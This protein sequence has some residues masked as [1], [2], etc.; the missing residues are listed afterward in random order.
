MG[1]NVDKLQTEWKKE[2]LEGSYGGLH[3]MQTEEIVFLIKRTKEKS[4]LCNV[5]V[6]DFHE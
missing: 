2:A 5:T 3:G 4:S 6:Y 1:W